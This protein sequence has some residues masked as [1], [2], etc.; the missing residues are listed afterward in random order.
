MDAGTQDQ[1]LKIRILLENHYLPGDLE[2][3]KIS[4]RPTSTSDAAK[5]SSSNAKGSN[6]TPSNDDNCNTRRKPPNLKL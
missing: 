1:T 3:H 6:A 2:A 4:P 5:S